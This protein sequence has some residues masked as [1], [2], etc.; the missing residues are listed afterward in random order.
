[1]KPTKIVLAFLLND[2]EKLKF[3]TELGLENNGDLCVEI[4][5]VK[6]EKFNYYI[7]N[8]LI[9]GKKG[10]GAS[11]YKEKIRSVLKFVSE[12]FF[13]TYIPAVRTSD[14]SMDVLQSIVNNRIS[15]LKNDSD[16][17]NALKLLEDKETKL[18]EEISSTLT[19]TLTKFL[20]DVKNALITT[21]SKRRVYS[22]AMWTL[23]IDDGNNTDISSK[24]DGIKSLAAIALLKSTRANKGFVAIEEPESHLHSGAIHKLDEVL[25]EISMHQQVLITTHNACFVN[26]ANLE[27]NIVV[28][29]GECSPVHSLDK[30]REELG[31]SLSETLI[32]SDNIIVVEGASDIRIYK[33]ILSI[34]SSKIEQ[35]LNNKTL[36]IIAAGSASKVYSL[37]NT[38]ESWLIKTFAIFDADESGK[39]EIENMKKDGK[40][41]Y[42]KLPLHGRNE[43][44]IEDILPSY[45]LNEAVSNVLGINIDNETFKRDKSKF[46]KRLK[47]FCDAS[48][49]ELTDKDKI[50]IKT[51]IADLIE[52]NDNLD[53]NL[54]KDVVEAIRLISE[55]IEKDFSL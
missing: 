32:V 22:R 40:H 49:Y 21:T 37:M 11:T 44:E 5:Y 15:E 25:R 4:T 3:K 18:M 46:C 2:D 28:S 41:N 54:S 23:M 42:A 12:N 52:H 26:L 7:P 45:I 6:N 43:T 47:K 14:Q 48:G 50:N 8:F 29:N 39:M 16:Y 20:P 34:F 53:N 24:G 38:Y 17:Y 19:P 1:M 13:F 35:S 36:S 30:L 51:N 9:K 31:I 55:R 33:K 27:S 10:R